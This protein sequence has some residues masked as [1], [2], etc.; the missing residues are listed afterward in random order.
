MKAANMEL[1]AG[2]EQQLMPTLGTS[3]QCDGEG[4]G[5]GEG[6]VDVVLVSTTVLASI[7]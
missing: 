1:A 6:V 4:E 3:I 7:S 2:T 5:D